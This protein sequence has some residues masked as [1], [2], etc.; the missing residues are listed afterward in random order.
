MINCYQLMIYPIVLRHFK[1]V[2]HP[3][4]ETITIDLKLI[5]QQRKGRKQERRKGGKE[6]RRKGG[7]EERRKGGGTNQIIFQYAFYINLSLKNVDLI[8]FTSTPIHNDMYLNQAFEK[9]D[10]S[11]I[12]QN[13]DV[14]IYDFQLLIITA[15]NRIDSK[16]QL[17]NFLQ[18]CS[19]KSIPKGMFISKQNYIVYM[20][21]KLIS[22]S[23]PL[24]LI[25]ENYYF[26]T[27]TKMVLQLKYIK[28]QI[29]FA[30]QFYLIKFNNL[31][32]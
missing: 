1:S 20:I 32:F 3:S 10:F 14:V 19:F 2:E 24:T 4:K 23:I 9:I 30:Q 26:G 29:A 28:A 13:Q 17:I 6:E 22:R 21:L 5:T 25:T 16:Q 11:K 12:L 18:Q 15:A 7:K 8:L 27:L 31:I